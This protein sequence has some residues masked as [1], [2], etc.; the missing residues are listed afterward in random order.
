MIPSLP[1][2]RVRAALDAGEFDRASALLKEHEREVRAAIATEP[3]DSRSRDTWLA[4][5]HA[6]RE[7]VEHLQAARSNAGS[8][9]QRLR[10]SHRGAAAYKAT[11][12]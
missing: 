2:A 3:P 9:L 4:L 8:A 7:L 11:S 5:L 1:I 6:Q 12:R 10:E